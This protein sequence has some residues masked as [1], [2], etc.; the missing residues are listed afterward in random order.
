MC[1]GQT[2]GVDSSRWVEL[3]D[4]L[5]DWYTQRPEEMKPILTIPA[6]QGESQSPFPT[7][8]YGNGPA[9]NIT[10][11]FIS[12]TLLLTWSV[13][14]NQLYHTATLLMLQRKPS[15]V[16]GLRKQVRREATIKIRY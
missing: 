4:L 16:E 15:G 9:G 3:L 1:N 12:R 11:S 10:N 14:G 5:D 8:F 2:H 6:A 7:V 13:S